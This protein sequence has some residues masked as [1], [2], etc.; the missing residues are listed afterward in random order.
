[1]DKKCNG[2]DRKLSEHI[3][4]KKQPFSAFTRSRVLT[5]I[6]T[7]SNRRRALFTGKER[8]FFWRSVDWHLTARSTPIGINDVVGFCLR[9]AITSW[10]H[11]KCFTINK[12]VTTYYYSINI[13]RPYTART[14]VFRRSKATEWTILVM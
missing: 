8:T 4:K 3:F 5:G 12:I 10:F 7:C 6:E 1:M 9:T 14:Y 11:G 13:K 2:F